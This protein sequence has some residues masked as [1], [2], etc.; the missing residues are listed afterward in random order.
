MNQFLKTAFVLFFLINFMNLFAQDNQNLVQAPD[1]NDRS[2]KPF[3]FVFGSGIYDL[4]GDISSEETC[5][6][7]S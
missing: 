3:K 4:T 2:I 7:K 6:I 1:E 5:I